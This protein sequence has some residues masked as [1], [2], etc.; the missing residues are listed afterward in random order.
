MTTTMDPFT[1]L[2][3][4]GPKGITSLPHQNG[5]SVVT[6]RIFSVNYLLIFIFNYFRKESGLYISQVYTVTTIKPK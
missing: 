6:L 4:L 5:T 1:K 3:I 2:E